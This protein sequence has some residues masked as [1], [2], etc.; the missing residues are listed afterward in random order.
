MALVLA[1]GEGAGQ[2]DGTRVLLVGI[3]E[4]GPGVHRRPVDVQ[5]VRVGRGDVGGGA[6]EGACRRRDL[7]AQV[8]DAVGLL[9]VAGGPQ[10]LGP[11]V[12]RPQRR[13]E[14]GRGRDRP[15]A[16]R[17]GHA[18]APS[19]RTPRRRRGAVPRRRRRPGERTAPCRCPRPAR[20]GPGRSG[21][22]RCGRPSARRARPDACRVQA[23]EQSSGSTPTGSTRPFTVSA[24][25][26][27]VPPGGPASG[28]CAPQGPLRRPRR[29]PRAAP[30]RE[31]AGHRGAGGDA[32]GR[33]EEGAPAEPAHV[34][35]P[36][37]IAH[38]V[39]AAVAVVHVARRRHRDADR[40]SHPGEHP[41]RAVPGSL[42]GGDRQRAGHA[43]EVA[44]RHRPAR[45]ARRWSTAPP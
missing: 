1:A 6:A 8:G 2:V 15:P 26:R 29:R 39:E 28:S 25:G 40:R 31:R 3:R 20:A 38:R 44:R 5:P 34:R 12:G 36:P 41:V 10:P 19:T 30:S 16:G 23:N 4:A 24:D 21:A 37:I 22:P 14:P 43:V 7:G 45:T 35:P 32:G 27:S 13:R 33:G 17:P 42:G 18:A 11:P 9:G